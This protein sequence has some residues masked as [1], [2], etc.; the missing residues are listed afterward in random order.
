MATC[1]TKVSRFLEK[2]ARTIQLCN[3]QQRPKQS[4]STRPIQIPLVHYYWPSVPDV[5][6]QLVGGELLACVSPSVYF[7]DM[8]GEQGD[9]KGY[10]PL[11]IPVA[12]EIQPKHAMS[13]WKAIMSTNLSK[14]CKEVLLAHHFPEENRIKT[15]NKN[16]IKC[17]QNS[18]KCLVKNF[19]SFL[20]PLK[21]QT[22]NGNKLTFN[23]EIR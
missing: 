8:Q 16:G 4:F 19:Y 10:L 2:L 5:K 6:A 18:I 23:K 14:R 3:L 21:K 11:V 12:D 22:N 13:F 20:Y 9:R 15:R 7:R 17:N 1:S